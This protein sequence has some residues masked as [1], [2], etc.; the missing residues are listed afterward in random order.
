LPRFPRIAWGILAAV[1]LAVLWDVVRIGFFADDFVFLDAARRMPVDKVLLGHYG[2]Y[3][4]YRPLARE[5]YFYLALLAGPAGRAITLGISLLTAT[6]AVWAL[7]DIGS[8]LGSR[9]RART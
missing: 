5:L 6:G 4:F 8:R 1:T 3:P 2:I 7:F 9:N